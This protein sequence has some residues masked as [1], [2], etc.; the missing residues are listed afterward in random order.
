M[1]RVC[2]LLT[3][4][5]CAL[6]LPV[7]AEESKAGLSQLDITLYPGQL[8]WLAICFPLFFLLMRFWILPIFEETQGNRQRV[9]DSD[10]E[11]AKSANEQA[12][13]TMVRYEK[14]LVGARE[15][16]QAT[17]ND[18]VAASSKEAADQREIQRVDLSNR[19]SA[20]EKKIASAHAT[21]MN[22]IKNLVDDLAK[23][24]VEK[25]AG[26]KV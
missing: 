13:Q 12:K 24:I 8:F 9:L 18:I 21:A 7:L 6:P 2:F 1:K 10:V 19:I 25:T 23:V 16:A 14:A 15:M 17:V 5:G 26:L 20:A 11:A 4:L 3:I 22:D